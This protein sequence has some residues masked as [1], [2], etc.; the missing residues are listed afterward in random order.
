MATVSVKVYIPIS[1]TSVLCRESVFSSSD[2]VMKDT[3]GCSTL[4]TEPHPFSPQIVVCAVLAVNAEISCVTTGVLM[5]VVMSATG[6][7]VVSG[8]GNS[9]SQLVLSVMIAIERMLSSPF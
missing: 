4:V 6:L 9:S 1:F 5:I 3:D 8:Y 7:D 2:N